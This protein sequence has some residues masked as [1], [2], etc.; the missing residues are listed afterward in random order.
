MGVEDGE[1]VAV[2]LREPQLRI[3][4]LQLEAVG[5]RSR[6]ASAL[7]ALGAAV[8]H[9]EET[10]SLV[11]GLRFGVR[12]ELYADVVGDHHQTV[13]SIADSTSSASQKSAERYFQPP[14]ARMATIVPSSRSAASLR[15]T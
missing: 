8:A 11:R 3:V 7:V 5:R 10:A 14:S 15:A 12:D 9:E 13:R 6:V 2:V 4:E 1:L